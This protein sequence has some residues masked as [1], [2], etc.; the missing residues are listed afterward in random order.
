M[1]QNGLTAATESTDASP[2]SSSISAPGNNAILN[3]N[4]QVTISG[5]AT[6]TGGGVVAGVEVSVDGGTTWHPATGSA[7]WSY[8]WTPTANGSYNILSRAVDD[9]GNLET[10]GTGVTV[11][12]ETQAACGVGGLELLPILPVLLWL[13]GL[14][15]RRLY[16]MESVRAV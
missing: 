10:P 4:H 16:A 2:P 13:R 12:V 14:R 6:D 5:T 1:L 15:R 3:V 11:S 7:S 8:T 9:S